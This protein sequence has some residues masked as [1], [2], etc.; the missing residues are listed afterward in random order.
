MLPGKHEVFQHCAPPRKLIT[1][2]QFQKAVAMVIGIPGSLLGPRTGASTTSDHCV[3]VI[4]EP[5]DQANDSLIDDPIQ[6][7][8]FQ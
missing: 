4:M 3:I 8:H 5:T 7:L 1:S 2:D 6:V